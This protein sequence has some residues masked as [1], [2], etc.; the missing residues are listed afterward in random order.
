MNVLCGRVKGPTKCVP[1]IPIGIPNSLLLV[2]FI[3]VLWASRIT[4]IRTLLFKSRGLGDIGNPDWLDSINWKTRFSPLSFAPPSM[5]YWC[6]R[7][8]WSLHGIKTGYA[9]RTEPLKG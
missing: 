1:V 7:E 9:N 8:W 2:H 4:L 6:A 5:K 3:L